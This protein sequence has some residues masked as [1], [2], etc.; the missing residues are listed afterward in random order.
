MKPLSTLPLALAL[1]LANPALGQEPARDPFTAAYTQQSQERAYGW[2]L[3]TDKERQEYQAKYRS[4]KTDQERDAFRAEHHKLM[5][6]R[7]KAQGKSLPQAPAQ[8]YGYGQPPAKGQGQVPAAPPSAR[9]QEQVYGS[10][11]MSDQER[12]EHQAKYRS[13]KTEQEREAFR[14]EHQKL[15]QERA[16]A[17][18]KSL[19]A[20]PADTGG[21]GQGKG[22]GKAQGK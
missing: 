8:G 4:L 5:Q 21:Y 9:A 22:K 14:A 19:P 6:E 15:M 13:L 20:A 1:V 3:M 10:Q 11:L 7:A 17:Q 18:G 2:E 16:K 12:K